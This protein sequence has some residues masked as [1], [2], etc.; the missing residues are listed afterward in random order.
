M[1]NTMKET[2]H[3][4]TFEINDSFATFHSKDESLA[5][6]WRPQRVA[7]GTAEQQLYRMRLFRVH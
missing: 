5:S 2:N 6:I 1:S 7:S 3:A 4:L